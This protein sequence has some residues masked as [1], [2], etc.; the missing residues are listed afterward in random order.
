[1][2]QHI[3]EHTVVAEDPNSTPSTHVQQLPVSQ[4]PLTCSGRL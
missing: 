3:R 4:L 1:M 2:A